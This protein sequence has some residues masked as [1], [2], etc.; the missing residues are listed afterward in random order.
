MRVPVPYV[1][2]LSS[3]LPP[4]EDDLCVE[5]PRNGVP[6]IAYMKPRPGDR[7]AHGNLWG[8]VTRVPGGRILFEQMDP[9]RQRQCMEGLLCQVCARPAEREG[10][11]LFIEWQH[12]DDR[13][14]Q[15]NRIR[16][17]MPPLCP[18]CAALSLRHC[19]FLRRDQ[20]VVLL[21]V[22]KSVPCG[23]AGTVYRVTPGLDQWIPSEFDI[24]SSYSKPRYPGMLSVRMLRKLNGVSVVDPDSLAAELEG[25]PPL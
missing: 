12:A 15:L 18:P 16:T 8:R 1:A 2:A 4:V 25:T 21:R 19:S 6:H 11:T 20:T 13:S 14:M 5:V 3:D 23:V 22:R 17:D 24:Y 9:V 7:D 10:G